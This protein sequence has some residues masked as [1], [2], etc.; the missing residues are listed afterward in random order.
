MN[1]PL[2][3]ESTVPGLIPTLNKTGWM[4]EAL[5]TY[6]SDFARYAG[7]CGAEVLDI[8]CAYGVATLTALEH[9][10]RVCACDIEPRH[11]HILTER[12]PPRARPRLRAVAGA[13]P[14]VDFPAATFGAVLASRVLHFLN[15][16]D[17]ELTVSKMHDWLRP[18]GRLYLIADTPFTGPWY[19]EAETYRQRK[20]AGERWPG[21]LN[22]YVNLLPAGTD[23][24]GHPEFINPLDPDLLSRTC[25]EAGFDIISAEFLAS[26]GPRPQHN[27]HAG[28]IAMRP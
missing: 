9:G 7:S 16:P 21:L 3:P 13:L 24:T 8:G 14:E 17:I 20:A 6:S 11:L 28:I 22:D 27:A 15:G 18:G 23:P 10:A 4:T 12:V 5:D 19:T 1:D 2:L 26:A 25:R